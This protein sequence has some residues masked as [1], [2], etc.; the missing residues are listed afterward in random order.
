[1][2]DLTIDF[3]PNKKTKQQICI[4]ILKLQFSKRRKT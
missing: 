2:L 1:M 3:A 4:N